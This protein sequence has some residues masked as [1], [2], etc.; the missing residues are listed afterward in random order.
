MSLTYKRQHVWPAVQERLLW[1]PWGGQQKHPWPSWR[2][3]LRQYKARLHTAW[4]CC[5][6][7]PDNL[8]AQMKVFVLQ[9]LCK[10]YGISSVYHSAYWMLD[11][12][13]VSLGNMTWWQ[14]ERTLKADCFLM[15][16]DLM[17]M[18][19]K[20][21]PRWPPKTLKDAEDWRKYAIYRSVWLRFAEMFDL[22]DAVSC[23]YV[24]PVEVAETLYDGIPGRT[25]PPFPRAQVEEQLSRSPCLAFVNG[26]YL[27]LDLSYRLWFNARPYNERYGTNLAERLIGPV[28]R[29]KGVSW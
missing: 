10:E 1:W 3:G 9:G 28:R 21:R 27:G 22:A 24:P 26:V 7:E 16:R 18:L 29:S 8:L 19:E 4:H 15:S 5:Q 12:Y 6:A 11:V 17:Q 13:V 2:E 25:L 23:V 20:R 14:E